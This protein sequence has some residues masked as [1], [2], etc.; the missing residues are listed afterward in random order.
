MNTNYALSK[1]RF[2]RI[3]VNYNNWKIDVSY[4]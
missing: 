2:N 4:F 1:Y 3:D